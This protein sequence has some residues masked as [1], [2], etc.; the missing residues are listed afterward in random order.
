VR[1]CQLTYGGPVGVIVRGERV[2]DTP[3]R[4]DLIL[5]GLVSKITTGGGQEGDHVRPRPPVTQEKRTMK[6]Q[7]LAAALVLVAPA[8]ALADVP[9]ESTDDA[10]LVFVGKVKK[11]TP[12]VNKF[13][14]GSEITYY[15]AQVAVSKVEKGEAAKAGETFEVMWNRVTKFPPNKKLADDVPLGF[16]YSIKEKAEARFYLK[17]FKPGKGKKAKTFWVPV[18]NKEAIEKVKKEEK[19]DEK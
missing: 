8:L 2:K 9:V 19:K 10:Q 14:D 13:G 15:T 18:Y 17:K 7:S 11:I 16:N 12:K 4:D 3:G 5:S 1:R 6:L